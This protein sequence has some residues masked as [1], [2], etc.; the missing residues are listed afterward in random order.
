MK[1]SVLSFKDDFLLIISF[2]LFGL[3]PLTSQKLEVIVTLFFFTLLSIHLILSRKKKGL[4][5]KLFFV[6][7][8]SLF[9]VLLITLF[10]GF[11]LLAYKKLEQM[12]SL[13]IFPLFFYLLSK[14]GSNKNKELF[15]LWKYVFVFAT[16]ILV[17][18]SFY[19]ISNYSNSRY[20]KLDSNFFQNAIIDSTYFSRDPAYISIYLNIS[21]LI[22]LSFII[23]SNSRKYKFIFSCL[24]LVFIVLVFM[25]SVKIAIIGLIISSIVLLFIKL[26]FKSFFKNLLFIIIP[27]GLF[28]FFAPNNINRFSKLFNSR[29]LNENT[30]YNSIFIHKQTILCSAKILKNNF[31]LGVGVENSNMLVN[32]CVRE[33]FIHN[34]K[35]IYN[36]HNQYLSYGLHSGVLGILLLG[37]VLYFALYNSFF[38]NHLIFAII[39]Y[40]AIIFFTENVLERQSGLLLFAFL[41][42]IIP[43]MTNRNTIILE[44]K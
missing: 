21:I 42:N 20:P 26:N 17:I 19:L 34:P 28:I 27:I 38:D 44:S 10:D 7:N 35:V 15:K 8:A 2:V 22:C 39:I 30:Q 29:V 36:S 1:G 25:L 31:L 4:K 18:I 24:G 43:N 6:L 40:F 23:D 33:V 3:I 14:E 37:F 11:D 13:L 16:F 41:I 32:N 9:F 5:N 12:V